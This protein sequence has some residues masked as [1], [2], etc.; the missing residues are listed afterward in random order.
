MTSRGMRGTRVVKA[1]PSHPARRQTRVRQAISRLR[2][3]SNRSDPLLESTARPSVS[4]V[5]SDIEAATFP[6]K[7]S[8]CKFALCARSSPVPGW[9]SSEGCNPCLAQFRWGPLSCDQFLGGRRR[10]TQRF[11]SSLVNC[12]SGPICVKSTCDRVL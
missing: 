3:V 2:G 7:H 6:S 1:L 9:R 12:R 4:L 5:W 11:P 8:V 10:K